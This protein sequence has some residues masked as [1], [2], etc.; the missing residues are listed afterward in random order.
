MEVAIPWKSLG[1]D[2]AP[3]SSREMRVNVQV[4]DRRVRE[5]KWETIPETLDKSSWTWP[6]FRLGENAGVGDVEV[7]QQE[8]AEIR[9][10]G[11]TAI[12]GSNRAVAGLT[13]YA[14]SGTLVAS[15]GSSTLHL[16]GCGVYVISIRYADGTSEHRKITI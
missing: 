15:G 9:I 3:S 12:V 11:C 7:S 10:E 13:A 16:P 4:R 14:V 8:R 1:E 6:E 5:L 2:K